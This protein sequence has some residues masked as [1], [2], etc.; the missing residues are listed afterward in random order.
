M[1]GV[2]EALEKVLTPFANL[3]TKPTWQKAQVLLVAALLTPRQRT[4]AA[5][6]RLLGLAQQRNFAKYHQGLNRAS[7]S[8]F[9]ASRLLL[10]SL[11][12]AFA[13]EGALGFGLAETLERR[14]GKNSKAKG[15][16]RDA[17]RSS[18]LAKQRDDPTT[19]WQ[20]TTLI[21]YQGQEKNLEV[22]SGRAVWYH[23]GKPPVAIRWVLIRDPQG[24]FDRQAL[25][26]TN[27]TIDPSQIIAWFPGSW[28]PAA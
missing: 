28:C 23:T 17:V 15:S 5:A 2:A 18:H 12:S 3:F 16:Y 25:L 21:C 4:V 10:G 7:W 22:A 24:E 6:L 13:S 20:S 26:C 27:L 19:A 8:T 9:A 1:V 14:W 11:L